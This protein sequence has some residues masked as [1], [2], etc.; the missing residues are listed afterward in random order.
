MQTNICFVGV[1]ERRAGRKKEGRGERED[2]AE[3][4]FEEIMAETFPNLMKNMNQ[5][6][7]AAHWTPSKMYSR[8][9]HWDTL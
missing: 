3:R 9:P 7:Q 1:P 2:W 6:M 4:M 8:D 5:N